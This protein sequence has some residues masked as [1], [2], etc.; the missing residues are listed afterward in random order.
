MDIDVEAARAQ[1]ARVV[2]SKTFETS[3]V[4]RHLL[5]YLADKTIAGD[6]DRLKEYTVGLEAF[7]KSSSYDPRHDSIVRLQVGR[8]R[9]KLLSYYQSEGSDDHVLIGLPK[10]AFRLT[11]EHN[12]R[13]AGSVKRRTESQ[14]SI[15]GSSVDHPLGCGR[16]GESDSS[17]PRFLVYRR[18]LEPRT[19]KRLGTVPA[20]RS[21]PAGVPGNS[22]VR[23][24]PVLGFLPR[25]QAE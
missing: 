3:E 24:L 6:A 11:F 8:L 20:K 17:T 1:I 9:Q 5:E 4:H 2:H 23:P 21:F 7:G 12:Q 22:H 10:G 13:T 18:A 15:P 25:S 19:R 14:T 16:D